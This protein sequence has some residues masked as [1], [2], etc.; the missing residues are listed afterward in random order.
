MQETESI[1]VSKVSH[2]NDEQGRWQRQASKNTACPPA[3]LQPLP[4]SLRVVDQ[5]Q[6][7]SVKEDDGSPTMKACAQE[8]RQG[9]DEKIRGMPKLGAASCNF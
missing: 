3:K 9:R 6:E 7:S 2:G 1:R 8:H 5:S 4:D